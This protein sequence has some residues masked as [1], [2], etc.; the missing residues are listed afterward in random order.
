MSEKGL[1]INDILSDIKGSSCNV[2]IKLLLIL[3]IT[4]LFVMSSIFTGYV[5]KSFEG[6]II[7]NEI[8]S[9]GVVI[10]S[11]FIVIIYALISWLSKHGMI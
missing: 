11:I 8:T 9:Y 4:I 5:T 6:A 1:Q 7:N 3:F 2:S 10:Q